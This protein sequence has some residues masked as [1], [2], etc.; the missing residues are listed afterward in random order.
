MNTRLQVEHPITE[1]VT[2]IDLVHWQIR[3]ARGERLDARSRTRCSTPRGH[4]IECRIY[5]EDP[6]HGFLPSPGRDPRAARAGR[7]RASATTAA[8][9][10]G[11]EVPIFY[12]PL[13]S[14]L[15]AWGEIAAEAIARM[16]RALGEYDV[17]GHQDDDPVLPLAAGRPGFPGRPHST[18]RS[19]TTCSP[20]GTGGRS[21]KCR[22]TPSTLPPSRWRCRHSA[23]K[24]PAAPGPAASDSRWQRAARTEALR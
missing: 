12:D 22:R 6:D 19:S 3:I 17:R 21:S 2:G 14:K 13:I 1:M 24:A 10:A 4:A 5:A 11:L 20:R 16:A 23:R 7:A 18:R 9:S 8:S 15:I